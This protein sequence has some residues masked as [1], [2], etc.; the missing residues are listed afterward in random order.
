VTYATLIGRHEGDDRTF[1]EGTGVSCLPDNLGIR[2]LAR[3]PT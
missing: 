2:R 3:S 1:G